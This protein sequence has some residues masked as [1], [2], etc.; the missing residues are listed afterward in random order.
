MSKTNLPARQDELILPGYGAQNNA[1][2][3]V[4]MGA[5][6]PHTTVGSS[7]LRNVVGG[8]LATIF[9]SLGGWL[10]TNSFWLMASAL[11]YGKNAEVEMPEDAETKPK[12]TLAEKGKG[13]FDKVAAPLKE[14]VHDVKENAAKP[15][16]AVVHKAQEKVEKETAKVIETGKELTDALKGNGVRANG[17]G[18]GMT[19]ADAWRARREAQEK[20][21]HDRLLVRA[22]AAGIQADES[23]SLARLEAEVY[24]VESTAW[25]KKWNAQCPMCRSPLQINDR[26]KR[27]RVRCKRC[28]QII[29]GG[30]AR[31]LGPPPMPRRL[32]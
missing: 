17:T 14:K 11:R 9:L 22:R 26:L 25:R 12:P 32:F 27:E 24:Q 23:W 3:V 6:Q 18:G 5:H 2:P 19:I 10:I 8:V 4:I 16:A 20:A 21:A 15:V 29:S 1:P 7:F 28:Q 31:S 13:L 30:T